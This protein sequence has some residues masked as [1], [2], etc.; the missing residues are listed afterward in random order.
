MN[1][2]AF[3]TAQPS[4]LAVVR[5]KSNGSIDILARS[6]PK[7]DNVETDP[8]IYTIRRLYGYMKHGAQTLGRRIISKI[9][10]RGNI[11]NIAIVQ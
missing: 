4:G 6:N 9:Y 11:N 10:N 2:T 8:K 5:L 7:V 1:T 3:Q